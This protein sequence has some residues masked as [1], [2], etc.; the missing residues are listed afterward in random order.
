MGWL[1]C[2]HHV[3]ELI[4]GAIFQK[5]FGK[6]KCAEEPFCKCFKTWFNNFT[7]DGNFDLS[8]LPKTKKKLVDEKRSKT[9]AFLQQQLKTAHPRKDYLEVI[10]YSL[11]NNFITLSQK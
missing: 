4:V 11:V 1:G 3:L 6:T 5:M 8:I 9:K 10:K 7:S 2:T